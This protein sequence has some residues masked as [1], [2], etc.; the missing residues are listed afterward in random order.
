MLKC[1]R[2]TWT[3]HR[4]AADLDESVRTDHPADTPTSSPLNPMSA[5]KIRA[6]AFAMKRSGELIL[7]TFD[8]AAID[9]VEWRTGL[10]IN[11]LQM[12]G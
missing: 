3:L 12:R 5:V 10:R 4:S 7:I 11:R 1:E 6:S 2:T 9:I 8:P